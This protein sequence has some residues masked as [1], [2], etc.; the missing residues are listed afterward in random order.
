MR[1][2]ILRAALIGALCA[3]SA[4]TPQQQ[5]AVTGDQ[6]AVQPARPT[7]TARTFSLRVSS[8]NAVRAE[9]YEVAAGV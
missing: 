7:F 9:H 5:S 6:R 3:G 4:C 2:R 1:N 8:E